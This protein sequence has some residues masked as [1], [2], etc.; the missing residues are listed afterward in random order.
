MAGIQRYLEAH[1]YALHHAC[2]VAHTNEKRSVCCH[3]CRD[4]NARDTRDEQSQF[5]I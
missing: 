1:Y 4:V 2:T 3:Y 5:V